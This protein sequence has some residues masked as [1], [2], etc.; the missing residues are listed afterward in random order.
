MMKIESNVMRVIRL[1][2]FLRTDELAAVVMLIVVK[3]AIIMTLILGF[4]G[5]IVLAMPV[6]IAYELLAGIITVYQCRR[7]VRP[8]LVYVAQRFKY[9]WDMSVWYLSRWS[10]GVAP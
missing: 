1:R 3:A 10:P 5:L 2:K 9:R 7:N 8:A 4:V 6:L